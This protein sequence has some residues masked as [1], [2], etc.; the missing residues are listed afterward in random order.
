M[1]G[2]AAKR[3]F[4]AALVAMLALAL[5]ACG[6]SSDSSSSQST[7]TDSTQS[8]TT[9]SGDDPS[10]SNGNG[11]GNQ[12]QG[13]GANS[14]ADDQGGS[15]GGDQSKS[16]EASAE[17]RTPGGDNSIQNYGDEA[18]TSELEEA[19]EAIVNYLDARAKANWAKSC[20]YLAALATE[21][22]EKLAES[23]PA[24][25][26]KDCGEIVGALSAQVPKSAL[27]SPVTEG[28]ASVR[29]KGDR[30]FAL[31]HGPGG[32]R[33]FMPLVKEDGEWKVGS[34]VASE[35]P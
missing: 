11:S 30:G 21:P 7:G 24:L 1:G 32:A 20:E 18:D 23:S 19:E 29:F 28:I 26:G 12:K 22:M 17:F 9:P 4:T 2:T 33:F 5:A 3:L 13:G 16:D 8:T 10:G 27:A 34:L 35:F 6:G 25:K 31:F 15:S 14:S